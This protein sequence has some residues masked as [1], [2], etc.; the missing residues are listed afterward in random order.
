MSYK[1]AEIFANSIYKAVC[2]YLKEEENKKL[3]AHRRGILFGFE[4]RSPKETGIV[5]SKIT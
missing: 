2:L 3:K 5:S 4:V 1:Y